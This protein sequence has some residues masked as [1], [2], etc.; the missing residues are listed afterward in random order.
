MNESRLEVKVG[1]FVFIGLAL[2]AVLLL[3]FSKGTNFF[4]PTYNIYLQAASV[5]GLKPRA[6]VL[7]SGVQVGMVAGLALGPQ[8]TNVTITLRIY[9]QYQIFKDARFVIEQSGF[10]GDEYVA[11]LPTRNVG[12]KYTDGGEAKA[13]AP[14]DLQEVAR[15]ASGFIKH[16]DETARK[17]NEIITDMRRLVLNDQTLTNIAT[18]AGNLRV[19]SERAITTLDNVNMLLDTNAV[20]IQASVSNLVVFSEQLNHFADSLNQ[21]VATNSPDINVAVKN[22]EASTATL[23]DLLDDVQAGKGLAG[24]LLKNEQIASNVA[25]IAYNLSITTSNLNRRGLWGILWSH[26]PPPTKEPPRAEA[27][28]AAPKSPFE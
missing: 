4:R 25:Q 19:A 18:S 8:G 3:Q 9:N 2:L 12:E 24:E 23:K 26:K 5:G 28:L 1:L 7:M 21:L 22:V 14:F 13:E 15:A 16:V 27:P 6:Q 11:I 17:L 20:P 10:L